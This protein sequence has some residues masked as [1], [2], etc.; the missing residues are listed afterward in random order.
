MC[1]IK[2]IETRR[3]YQRERL[4]RIRAEKRGELVATPT[5]KDAKA[6]NPHSLG[7]LGLD[8]LKVCRRD[9]R[10]QRNGLCQVTTYNPGCRYDAWE[11]YRLPVKVVKSESAQRP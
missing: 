9:C 4:R 1:P 6:T 8:Y 10:N 11:W 7:K 2:N 5:I 3:R